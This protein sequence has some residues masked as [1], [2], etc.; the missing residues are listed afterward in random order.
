MLVSRL[1]TTSTA[2][3]LFFY[4][5]AMKVLW[6]YIRIS[7]ITY[8]KINMKNTNWGWILIVLIVMMIIIWKP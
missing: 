7:Q 4:M 3:V 6:V 8:I 2:V 5:L 1:R